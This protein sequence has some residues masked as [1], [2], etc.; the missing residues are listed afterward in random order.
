MNEYAEDPTL[1]WMLTAAALGP[2]ILGAA[3]PLVAGLA[4]RKTGEKDR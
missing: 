4:P 2:A 3:I 1:M